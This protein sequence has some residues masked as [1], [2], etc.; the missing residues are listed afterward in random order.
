MYYPQHLRASPQLLQNMSSSKSQCSHCGRS[1]KDSAS[2]EEL[3]ETL[4][5]VNADFLQ[6]P[7]ISGSVFNISFGNNYYEKE[8]GERV[9]IKWVRRQ[10]HCRSR[11]HL[12]NLLGVCELADEIVGAFWQKVKARGWRFKVMKPSIWYSDE[13]TG[14]QRPILVEQ[15]IPGFIKL[16]CNSGWAENSD[17]VYNKVAQALSHFSFDFSGGKVLLCDLQGSV[18]DNHKAIVL[19]DPCIISTVEGRYGCSDLGKPGL[20]NFFRYHECNGICRQFA[21]PKHRKTFFRPVRGTLY[22]V[23]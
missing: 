22:N 13:P 11:N 2:S 19:A 17:R 6:Q 5:G 20:S 14:Q 12:K 3:R 23:E 18:W 7:R 16:N 10:H 21:L 8:E 15:Y 1:K 4:L 9:V